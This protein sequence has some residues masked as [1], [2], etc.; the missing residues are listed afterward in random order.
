LGDT[1]R[2]TNDEFVRKFMDFQTR[3]TESISDLIG[4][5]EI[6]ENR[7]DC[8]KE[9][10]HIIDNTHQLTSQQLNNLVDLTK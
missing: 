4:S 3:K 2:V 6:Q 5:L 1:S 7:D 9:V 10:L 8:C